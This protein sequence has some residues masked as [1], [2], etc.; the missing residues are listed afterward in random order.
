MTVQWRPQVAH[1]VCPGST[2][3]VGPCPFGH[4]CPVVVPALRKRAAKSDRAPSS[5]VASGATV[6]AELRARFGRFARFAR[7]GFGVLSVV[8]LASVVVSLIGD[9]PTVRAHG[10]PCGTHAGHGTVTSRIFRAVSGR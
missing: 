4:V 1:Q 5:A 9:A 6:G 7:W 8:G 2:G 3:S 10:S